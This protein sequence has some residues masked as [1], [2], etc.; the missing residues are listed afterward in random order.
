MSVIITLLALVATLGADSHE[1]R[2][3]SQHSIRT[4]GFSFKSMHCI[5]KIDVVQRDP[6]VRLTLRDIMWDQFYIDKREFYQ[7][8][9]D[10][11]DMELMKLGF[12][13]ALR[14]E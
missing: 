13:D 4:G 9:D 5:Y 12:D 10:Q 1:L 3:A 8:Y 11:P 14:Y 7:G 6:E 2:V